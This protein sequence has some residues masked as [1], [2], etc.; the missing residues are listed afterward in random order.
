MKPLEF[1]CPQCG[2]IRLDE[3]VTGMAVYNKIEAVWPEAYVEY[4]E[5]S[6]T[7]ED[8]SC[9]PSVRFQCLKCEYVLIAD[10]G[11]SVH[12][13]QELVEWIN[14]NCSFSIETI[15]SKLS[16]TEQQARSIRA[17]LFDLE[18]LQ[19]EGDHISTARRYLSNTGFTHTGALSDP[20]A[21]IWA[22][23]IEIDALCS[24]PMVHWLWYVAASDSKENLAYHRKEE[25]YFW[26]TDDELSE[27]E[28][29]WIKKNSS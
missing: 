12:T 17:I 5:E 2:D 20:H 4:N 21:V 16:V 23:S 25:Y 3:V 13:Q 10:S 15:R 18:P 6:T 1:K 28:A 7:D 11:G 27:M 14:F 8:S 22:T 19:H 24:V 29:K 9:V 26:T